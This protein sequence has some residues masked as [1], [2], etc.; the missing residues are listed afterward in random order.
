MSP[1]PEPLS[2]VLRRLHEAATPGP[3]R[4]CVRCGIVAEHR[5]GS[6]PCRPCA[7]K[8][9]SEW[10]ATHPEE[11]KRHREEWRK[12]REARDPEYAARRKRTRRNAAPERHREKYRERLAWL[13]SGSVTR[14]Q[15]LEVFAAANG[16]C[17]WCGVAVSARFTPSDPRGF[18]HVVPRAVGGKHEKSNLVV[19]CR[20]CNCARKDGTR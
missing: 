10:R 15:L 1:V 16:T 4:K 18:D 17:R 3:K 6:G 9:Q 14:E 7:A 13:R 5:R 20:A 11:T 19:S 12:R 8:A 2:Q